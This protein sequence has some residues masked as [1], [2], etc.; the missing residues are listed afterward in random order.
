M[1]GH[2]DTLLR[3]HGML[4]EQLAECQEAI[5]RNPR[6]ADAR[7]GLG[8]FLLEFGEVD[9]AFAE[10]HKALHLRPNEPS[11]LDTLGWA[12][13]A[14]G[15]LKQALATLR[16]ATRLQKDRP[17][18]EIQNHLK[19]VDRLS[20]LEGR[21]D[22][23]LQGRDVPADANAKLDVADLCRVMRRFA[24]SARYYSAAFHS[25]PEL[26]DDAPSQH[27]LHAAVAA[28]Q[29]ATNLS[30][31]NLDDAER[32]RWRAQSLDWLRAEEKASAEILA[33][34]APTAPAPSQADTTDRP[35]LA[36]ARKTL[37]ILTHH[38][39]LACVRDEK[40]LAKLAEPERKEWQAFWA[41]V[42]VLLE[43]ADRN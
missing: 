21:L 16:E 38:R 14:S 19:L 37:D 24:V 2:L 10:I 25:K 13:L 11:Y 41:E 42:A 43:S 30:V 6:N 33:P 7:N 5:R 35:K 17:N 15:D 34:S 40:E 23:I 4:A 27:R 28:A 9:T 22:A 1:R 18:A 36:V 20:T 26:A 12:Y 29:A 3:R 39:H 8:Y 32:R 31:A